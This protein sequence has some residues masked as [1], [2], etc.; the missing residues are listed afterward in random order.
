M[1]LLYLSEATGWSGG[2]NQVWLTS[3][4]FVRRGHRVAVACPEGELSQRLAAAGIPVLPLAISQDYDLR[5]AWRVARYAW[6]LG[7]DVVHAHHPRAHA[8]GLLSTAL[9]RRAPLVVT[10][11]VLFPVQRNPFSRLKYRSRWVA[12]YIAVC[13]PIADRLVEAGVEAGRIAVIPSGVDMKRWEASRR[14]RNGIEGRRPWTVTMVGHY[15]SFKGH[16]VLLEAA[17]RVLKDIPDARFL[18]VGRDTE[19][20]FDRIRRSGLSASVEPMGARTDVDDILSRTHLFV[21]PSLMEGIGSALIEALA[22]GVPAVASDVGGLPEVVEHGVS[23]V[24]VPPGNSA[25][26]AG[27]I[28][29]TLQHYPE[30]LAMAEHGHERAERLFSIEAVVTRL[31]ELYAQVCGVRN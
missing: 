24:L 11:R 13:K 28:A 6:D 16:E 9:G 25:A 1:N 30:A 27:A 5:S 29:G 3:R 22:A 26:L 15:A 4:E 20:L 8:V 10:R 17:G 7:I 14:A 23:G 18:L 12:R 2:A 21:M 31:E 19:K